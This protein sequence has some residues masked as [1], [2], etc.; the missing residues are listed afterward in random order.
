[1]KPHHFI[2]IT[3]SVFLLGGCKQQD[4]NS[5][6]LLS[7]MKNTHALSPNDSSIY[8]FFPSNQCKNC[9]LYNAGFLSPALNRHVVIITEFDSTNFKGFQNFHKDSGNGLIQLTVLDYGNKI[10]T[11]KEGL[12]NHVVA[13]SDLYAQLDSTS[14][15]MTW[16]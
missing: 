14:L 9:F 6:E 1:M 15:T 2:F 3:C 11:F 13:V 4:P 5:K 16:H 10:I 7:Y 8:C 12:I